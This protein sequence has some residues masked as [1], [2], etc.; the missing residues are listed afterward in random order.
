MPPG[1]LGKVAEGICLCLQ[2]SSTA[3]TYL[4]AMLAGHEWGAPCLHAGPWG[5][6][7]VRPQA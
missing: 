6:G 5:G 4:L 2:L 7:A 3:L 1:L